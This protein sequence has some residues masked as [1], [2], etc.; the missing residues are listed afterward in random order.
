MV[1]RQGRACQLLMSFRGAI[2]A[3]KPWFLPSNTAEAA[4]V[5]DTPADHFPDQRLLTSSHDNGITWRRSGDGRTDTWRNFSTTTRNRRNSLRPCHWS[6]SR[7]GPGHPRGT[8]VDGSRGVP[9]GPRFRTKKTAA[10]VASPNTARLAA[11]V[12]D[13]ITARRPGRP[14]PHLRRRHPTGTRQ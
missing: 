1:H 2:P 9:F 12:T 11:V 3:E 5:V 10:P 14:L 4:Y 13:Q 7:P 8:P 6:P